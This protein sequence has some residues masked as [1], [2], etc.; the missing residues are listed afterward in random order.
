M[1][2]SSKSRELISLQNLINDN[3]AVHPCLIRFSVRQQGATCREHDTLD[4]SQA[5]REAQARSKAPYNHITLLL[6]T[7]QLLPHFNPSWLLENLLALQPL[8]IAILG[9]P[10]I[11]SHFTCSELQL[12]LLQLG[13][14]I[15]ANKSL[16]SIEIFVNEQRKDVTWIP[17][18]EQKFWHATFDP[19]L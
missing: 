18:S 12:T 13:I 8:P 17:S 1:T 16:K 3:E 7:R 6:R 9:Y 19:P 5:L 11:L 4:N 10:V 14:A 2:H 15:A